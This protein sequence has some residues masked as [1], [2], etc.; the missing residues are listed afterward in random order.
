ML[1]RR[2]PDAALAR[3]RLHDTASQPCP[4]HGSFQQKA[5]SVPVML[6]MPFPSLP[7]MVLAP[8]QPRHLK[9]SRND[10]TSDLRSGEVAVAAPADADG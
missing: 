9:W 2:A 8:D 6:S 1:D 3:P 4:F 5:T 7:H 10:L